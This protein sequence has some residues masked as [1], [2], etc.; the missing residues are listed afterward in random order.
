MESSAKRFGQAEVT[1]FE[2]WWVLA[3]LVR[4]LETLETRFFFCSMLPPQAR[5]DLGLQSVRYICDLDIEG[6]VF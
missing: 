2:L 6:N 4:D 3:L 5:I 1:L